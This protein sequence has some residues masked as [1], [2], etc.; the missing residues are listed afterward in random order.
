MPLLKRNSA[1]LLV[2]DLQ[3]RL[4]AD[5]PGADS[6]VDRASLLMR[7]AAELDI[8]VLTTEQY[9]QG[10][11]PTRAPLSDL[12]SGTP[13]EKVSFGC[14]G[15][16]EFPVILAASGRRQ[17]VLSGAET[18]ICVLQTAVGALEAGY[19]V[20]VV[21]DAVAS[22][23][24]V[25]HQAGLDRMAREGVQLITAEMAVFEWLGR[26]GTPAFKR[27]LPLIK[28]LSG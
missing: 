3:E 7:A 23:R 17:L 26:A 18:H 15:D 13:H 28:E 1:A 14:F 10:L 5:I 16:G 4:L 21:T 8:P 22:R 24:A 20:F 6:V 27:L 25:Q 12:A 19:E 11:G 2:I 9:P